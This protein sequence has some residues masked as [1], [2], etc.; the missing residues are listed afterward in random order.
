[1]QMERFTADKLKKT[2]KIIFPEYRL[3]SKIVS[4][5]GTNFIQEKSKPSTGNVACIIQHH[6]HHIPS[7]QWTSRSMH[8]IGQ[9]NNEKM[10]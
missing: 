1:M 10:L 4:D 5:V 6:Y 7:E 9:D 2:C 8:K 3:S